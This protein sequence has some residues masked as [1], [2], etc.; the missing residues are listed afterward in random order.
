MPT[1]AD[2]KSQSITEEI[3]IRNRE[4]LQERKRAEDLLYNVSEG[5]FAVDKEFNITIFNHTLETMLSLPESV[6]VG[7][8]M[9]DVVIIENEKNERIDL[10]Q[11]CFLPP[12]I[13]PILS[14]LVL[15]GSPNNYFVN[16]HF[17]VIQSER[18]HKRNHA[19]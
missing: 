17:S 10:K 4:L 11:Y 18:H 2:P 6:A 13:T 14:G 12:Q 9:E 19:R 5:V 15:K 8:K 16:I 1:T 3:Y 7:K